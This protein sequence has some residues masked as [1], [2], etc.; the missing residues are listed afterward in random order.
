MTQEH[1]NLVFVFPDQFRRQALGFYGEDPVVTPCLDR[2]AAESLVLTHAVSNYP[3]CSPYRAQLFTG[4]YPFSNGVIGNCYSGTIPYG[5]ELRA[6]ERCLSDVLHDVGY[7]LG[8]VGKLH[9]DLP[10]EEH[11]PFTEGWRGEPG[12][13]TFW[14]SY[15]PPGARRH[16]FDFWHSYGC[17][18]WHLNPHYWEGDA[19][20]EERI[21]VDGWSVEHE[22]DVALRYLHDRSGQIR[23]PE[24]PF[25]LFVAYN[26]PHPPY[27][28]VPPRYRE[29]YRGQG[30]ADLLNRSNVILDGP[31]EQ[32]A[33]AVQDYFAA[34]TGI[35]EQFGRIL[36]ALDEE[37]LREDT[38]VVFT[39]DHGEMM[40]SHGRMQ[41]NVWYDE[42]ALIPFIA[43][44]PGHIQAGRDDLLL[45][46]PDVFPSL[47]S[48]MELAGE[49]PPQ[50]EGVDYSGAFLGQPVDRPTS[51]LILG[52]PPSG[53]SG[54]YRALRTHD[55]TFAID[56][57][58]GSEEMILYD[59]REDPYQLANVAGDRPEVVRR[60]RE[61]L[62]DWLERTGDPFLSR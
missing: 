62:G 16:G 3:I 11:I 40:G 15:T 30:P 57:S 50:V 52:A 61:E 45:S 25:A 2:F 55:H 32:A 53:P 26:P 35:D 44:W 59:N 14:D 5:I 28:L 23:D 34:V 56:R 6:D 7:S 29:H 33:G 42:A 10:K 12:K 18:D 19:G 4:K 9:L 37:G 36:A 48:L 38:I 31:G 60:L 21:D 54:G 46:A 1:P 43:R 41:K 8:Y 27:Q 22:T 13:G 20:I 24:N 49:I 47:L 17:C 39:A 51:A 58:Q